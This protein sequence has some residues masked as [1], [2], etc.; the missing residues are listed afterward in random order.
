M[1]ALLAAT[2]ALAVAGAGCGGDDFANEPRPAAP[3][4][5]TAKIDD[6]RVVVSPTRIDGEP[7][8]A[9]LANV[10]VS[11]MT[12]DSVQLTFSGPTEGTTDPIVAGGVL[13]YKLDL[14]QGNYTV[15]ADEDA[16]R[17]FEMRI[18]EPRPSSQNDLLLP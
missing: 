9:G 18:G 14:Q 3:I 4:E 2:A 1:T 7:V 11:N 17:S 13:E 15:A 12:D 6:R 8:G 10:T 16:I 5:L